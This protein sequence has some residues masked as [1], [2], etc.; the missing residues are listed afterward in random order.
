[1]NEILPDGN[2][3][4]QIGDPSFVY[5]NVYHPIIWLGA[6]P[7]RPRV[8]MLT[9]KDR[10]YVFIRRYEKNDSDE[11]YKYNYRIPGGSIDADSDKLQQAIAETNEEGLLAVKNAK[12]SG[13]SYYEQYQPGFL[14][15]GGDMPIEYKGSM[16]DVFVAEYAGKYDKSKVEEKDLDNDMATK[17]KFYAIVSIAKDLKPEHIRALVYSG[18]VD[19]DI[20]MFLR[21]VSDSKGFPIEITSTDPISTVF[22]DNPVGIVHSFESTDIV[23]PGGKLYHGTTAMIDKFKPMSLDIGNINQKPGWSTFCFADYNL[24]KRFGLMRLI[25]SVTDKLDETRTD[26]KWKNLH[27][28]WNVGT[29]RPFVN[30]QNFNP[31]LF[32]GEKFYVYTIAANRLKELGFGND[33]KLP[34]YTFRDSDVTPDA[35]EPIEVSRSMLL[36]EVMIVDDFDDVKVA[37]DKAIADGECESSCRR[38]MLN[39]DYNEDSVVGKL[40][41][42]VQTGELKPGDDIEEFMAQKGWSFSEMSFIGGMST[43]EGVISDALKKLGIVKN[44]DPDVPSSVIIRN[45]FDDAEVDPCMDL[46]ENGFLPFS[47]QIQDEFDKKDKLPGITYKDYAT[48]FIIEKNHKNDSKAAST[49]WNTIP[50]GDG[51]SWPIISIF[52]KRGKLA[53][54]YIVAVDKNRQNVKFLRVYQNYQLPSTYSLDGMSRSAIVASA[55]KFKEK[56]IQESVFVAEKALTAKQ[57]KEIPNKEYGLPKKRKYPMPDKKHVRAAIRFFNYVDKEDE[58]ELAR[59][60]NKMVKKYGMVDEIKVGSDNRFSK[61]WKGEVTESTGLPKAVEVLAER[62]GCD[63]TLVTEAGVYKRQAGESKD[64]V[65]ARQFCA[66]VRALANKK[67]LPFFVVTNGA[68]AYSNGGNDAIRH[69]RDMHIEWE[70]THGEDPDEDWSSQMESVATEASSMQSSGAGAVPFDVAK[71]IEDIISND[72]MFISQSIWDNLD[73]IVYYDTEEVGNSTV[74]SVVVFKDCGSNIGHLMLSVD[75][76]ATGFGVANDLMDD[77][78]R[79]WTNL[80][81]ESIQVSVNDDYDEAI[82]LFLSY[83]FKEV[84][85]ESEDTRCFMLSGNSS[86]GDGERVE[87]QLMRCARDT[88]FQKYHVSPFPTIYS[89]MSTTFYN[90]LDDAIQALNVYYPCDNGLYYVFTKLDN[91]KV[92][93]VGRIILRANDWKFNGWYDCFKFDKETTNQ[94]VSQIDV[95]EVSGMRDEAIH[96]AQKVLRGEHDYG[97]LTESES[98]EI[99]ANISTPDKFVIEAV[100]PDIQGR[101]YRLNAKMNRF[102]YGFLYKGKIL[103]DDYSKYQTMTVAEID[104]YQC[105]VCW[106]FVNYEANWFRKNQIPFKTFYIEWNDPMTSTHTFLVYKLPEDP[107]YYYFES[108]FEKYQGV[109]KVISYSDA[110]DL[111]VKEMKEFGGLDKYDYKVWEYAASDALSHMTALQYMKTITKVD[112]IKKTNYGFD[113]LESVIMEAPGDPDDPGTATDY[114]GGTEPPAGNTMTDD[115]P[116]DYTQGGAGEEPTNPVAAPGG[117]DAADDTGAGGDAAGMDDPGEE[118]TDYTDAGADAGD[119]MGGGDMGEDT[120]GDTGTDATTSD[121]SNNNI[122]VKNYSLIKDFEKAYTLIDDINSTIDSTLKASSVQNQVLVQVSRNLSNVKDFIKSFVQFHFKDNDYSYNLYYY[123]IVIQFLKINLAMVEKITLLGD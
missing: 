21:R 123:M 58:A 49:S 39:R 27:C 77:L 34:E 74:G 44:V 12:F 37:N 8:E 79:N 118:P 63:Y 117:D 88:M 23:V 84:E 60:I 29:C 11:N 116:T 61:Y 91:Q 97:L 16:N 73:N 64:L 5:K 92:I 105:G 9:I 46:S 17:G 55:N 71:T 115:Q 2:K 101:I 85:A 67:N 22:N 24:A 99:W 28:E 66:D 41:K 107:N 98:G 113:I 48:W 104:R 19:S 31:N 100:D 3:P 68:S 82:K 40:E 81:V 6:D 56:N 106:D 50:G 59:N 102:K 45:A 26:P 62:M 103:T 65:K 7:Y 4:I 38:A 54:C 35:V 10:R 43:M 122:V 36:E 120:G 53:H 94:Y 80:G 69:A 109:H 75:T 96:L 114:T 47:K 13:V 15:K 72:R 20:V 110:I 83:G 93:P 18:M 25:Q 87:E 89:E 70:N 76:S 78:L 30:R 57:R 112:P 14:L 51:K 108:S 33:S 119:D 42:A 86:A 95:N 52:D 90:S 1:M 32:I 111:V 121:S